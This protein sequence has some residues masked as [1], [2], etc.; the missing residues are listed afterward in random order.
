M[1]AKL[2]NDFGKMRIINENFT[3]NNIDIILWEVLRIDKIQ[4]IKLRFIKTNSSNRQ[5]IRIGVD[6]SDGYMIINNI[7]AKSFELWE[8]T[9]PKEIEVECHSDEGHLSIYNIF[10]RNEQGIMRK[11]SQMAYSGMILERNENIYKYSCNAKLLYKNGITICPIAGWNE[12][13]LS[14]ETE[15]SE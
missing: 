2:P 7:K 4:R 10:E 3:L 5:G 9:C 13:E 1:N 11:H 12:Y 6:S 8:D 15:G 14:N